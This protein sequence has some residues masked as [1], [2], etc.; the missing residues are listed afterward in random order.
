MVSGFC[1]LPG[2]HVSG[3]DSASGRA[4]LPAVV[5]SN[6]WEGRRYSTGNG[7]ARYSAVIHCLTEL[8]AFRI[9]A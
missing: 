9:A 8:V 4:S 1:P 7:G 3:P 2:W 5:F 6:H